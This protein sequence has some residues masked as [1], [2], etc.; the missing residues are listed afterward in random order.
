MKKKTI[1]L[2][3][4]YFLILFTSCK[5][6]EYDVEKHGIHFKKISQSD[7]GT[8]IGF[9][10]EN[11]TIDGY[12]CAKGWIHF[13]S[14]WQLLSFQI[15]EPFAFR[16]TKFPA[17]TWIHMPYHEE[18]TNYVVS[19]PYDMEIQ[20]YLCSGSGGYGGT[21]TGFYGNGKLRSFFPP[22]N[23]IIDG[24]PC[25]STPFQNTILHESGKLKKCKLSADFEQN[26]MIYKKG[27]VID[28]DENGQVK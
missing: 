26:G 8:I 23:I 1:L 10:S 28:F 7:A 22:E 20:G 16:G 5:E 2:I 19:L 13:R 21:H 11:Q 4:L 15:S 3:S 6:W 25:K 12:P 14:N 18:S 17:K 27:I 24:V 9:M